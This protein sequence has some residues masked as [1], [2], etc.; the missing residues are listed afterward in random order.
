MLRAL[1]IAAAHPNQ[2]KFSSVTTVS[3]AIA[4]AFDATPSLEAT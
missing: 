4:I 3:R 2:V 1:A